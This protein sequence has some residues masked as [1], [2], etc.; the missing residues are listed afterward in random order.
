MN[1]V[2]L[3]MLLVVSSTGEIN[4]SLSPLVPENL[5][6][7]DGFDHP[8]PRHSAHSPHTS[9]LNLVLTRGIP[10]AFRGG[11]IVHLFIRRPPSYKSRVY[12]VTQL[13]TDGIHCRGSAGTGPVVLKVVRVKGAAFSGV[14]T[15]DQLM[16]ASLVP[17][18][19]LIFSGHDDMCLTETIGGGI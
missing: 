1:R 16:C 12:Q 7:R 17:H 9:R 4:V 5:V 14:T 13:R 19:Q 11:V 2:R 8:V 15:V 3:P 10:P 18:P 6:S